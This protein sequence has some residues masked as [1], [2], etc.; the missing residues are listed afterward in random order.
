MINYNTDKDGIAIISFNMPDST[1]NM[2]NIASIEVFERRIDQAIADKAVKGIIITS[3][4]KDFIVGGDLNHIIS[5]T[6]PEEVMEIVNRFHSILRKMETGEKPVVAAINGTALGGGYEV[7]LACHH[8]IVVNDPK[9]Q[10]GLPEVQLG[11]L[12][13]GG[14]TQRLP[15]MIGIQRSLKVLLEGKRMNPQQAFPDA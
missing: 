15:R 2:L 5:I 6:K 10:I 11:L 4:K 9:I 8:R 12:P 14:G 3:G 13:G 1:V 7:C